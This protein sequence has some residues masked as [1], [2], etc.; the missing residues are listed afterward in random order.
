[1]GLGMAGF[2]LQNFSKLSNG[3]IDPPVLKQRVAEIVAC[4]YVVGGCNLTQYL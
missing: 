3:F 2:E 1:M 4:V